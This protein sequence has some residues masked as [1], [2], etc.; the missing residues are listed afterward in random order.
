M[1]KY[2]PQSLSWAN[3]LTG[4]F[5]NYLFERG[6]QCAKEHNANASFSGIPV[7]AVPTI[8]TRL[9]LFTLGL[10]Q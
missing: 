4:S 9:A 7:N 8:C 5:L 10:I 1:T 2:D 6:E 3:E